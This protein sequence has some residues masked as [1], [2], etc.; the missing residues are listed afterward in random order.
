MAFNW[1]YKAV[2]RLGQKARFGLVSKAV[3]QE[4][5]RFLL[6]SLSTFVIL[7]LGDWYVTGLI[8]VM[9]RTNFYLLLFLESVVF[10]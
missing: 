1:D 2:Y 6:L 8:C 10:Y 4:P 9:L 3:Y 5:V 7:D